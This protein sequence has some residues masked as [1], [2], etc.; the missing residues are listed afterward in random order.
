MRS[1]SVRLCDLE[2]V[3]IPIG[4][5]GE[6]IYTKVFIDCKKVFDEHPT[7]T[8]VLVVTPPRGD[9]Y[10]AV[11]SREGDM[12][13]WE[14]TSSD[15]LYDGNGQIQLSFIQDEMIGKSYPGRTKV[16][17][18]SEPSGES[19]D[20][21]ESWEAEF[22]QIKTDAE[23]ARDGAV[24][25]KDRA[26]TVVNNAIDDITNTATAQITL[27]TNEGDAQIERVDQRVERVMNAFSVS[28]STLIIDL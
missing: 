23:N 6:N 20:P 9:I 7:A 18:S 1:V 25:A 10:P 17:K 26:E 13:I 2:K 24:E 8:A 16:Y 19:P 28:G 22:I 15:L 3:T 5:V 11:T 14:V 27:I 12:V 21:W 4:F